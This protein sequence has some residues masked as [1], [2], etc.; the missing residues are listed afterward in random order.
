M[1]TQ[2]YKNHIRFY[3]PH[4]FVFYP[5]VLLL[6]SSAI[7]YAIT[8]IHNR[9]IWTFISIL[10]VVIGWLS[11]MMRQHYAL[12][13]QNRIIRLEMRYRYFAITKN[14]FEPIEEMLT[15]SQI[16]ALRFATDEELPEWVQKAVSAKLSAH[17]IKKNIL[18]WRPDEQRV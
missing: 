2:N 4:H 7:Y 14:R 17:A 10:I 9:I 3:P 16:Y 13:L 15:E 12:T 11:F 8:D 1:A 6:L 18:N 5:I